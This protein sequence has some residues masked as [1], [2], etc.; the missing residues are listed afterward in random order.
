MLLV[1]A[2]LHT[3]HEST[4]LLQSS[5]TYTVEAV[6]LNKLILLLLMVLKAT[7]YVS[8]S[9]IYLRQINQTFSCSYFSRYKITERCR[10]F[11]GIHIQQ[12]KM[13]TAGAKYFNR[14]FQQETRSMVLIKSIQK[15]K[16]IIFKCYNNCT[17]MRSR[18]LQHF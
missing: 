18:K 4:H 12:A 1:Y 7:I 14:P 6:F 9:Q 16:Y 2:H 8:S 10:N 11:R 17:I 15:I 5:T 3:C 13:N